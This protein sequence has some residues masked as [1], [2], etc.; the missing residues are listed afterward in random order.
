M[1]IR[2]QD[3][4]NAGRVDRVSAEFAKSPGAP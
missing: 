4:S 2:Q 1:A 3:A